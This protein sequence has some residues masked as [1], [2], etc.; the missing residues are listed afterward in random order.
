MQEVQAQGDVSSNQD[1]DSSPE[2]LHQG[3]NRVGLDRDGLVLATVNTSLPARLYLGDD[4]W[5]RKFELHDVRLSHRAALALLTGMT[6]PQ[7]FDGCGITPVIRPLIVLHTTAVVFCQ[8]PVR[9]EKLTL[10]DTNV[11]DYKTWDEA[12]LR[13]LDA[14]VAISPRM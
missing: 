4:R 9:I 7:V 8:L 6:V 14:A 5:W 10:L 11:H 3:T 1:S 2:G 12:R 13:F